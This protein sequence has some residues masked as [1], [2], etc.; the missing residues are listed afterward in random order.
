MK[1]T[2]HASRQLA[3]AFGLLAFFF[4]I[5]H[6]LLEPFQ[7]GPLLQL[8]SNGS[9]LSFNIHDQS[10][11]LV[12]FRLSRLIFAFFLFCYLRHDDA[13]KEAS[14]LYLLRQILAVISMAFSIHAQQSSLLYLILLGIVNVLGMLSIIFFIFGFIHRRMNPIFPWVSFACLVLLIIGTFATLFTGNMIIT[15]IDLIT[16]VSSFLLLTIL[17]SFLFIDGTS[18]QKI[19]A[20]S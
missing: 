3:F 17:L 10:I 5:L 19:S 14:C 4:F 20:N 6:L 18:K 1:S 2:F 16:K 15:Y 11:F 12:S 13:L 8:M 7:A 9:E